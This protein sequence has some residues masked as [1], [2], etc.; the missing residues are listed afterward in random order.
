VLVFLLCGVVLVL[1][2]VLLLPL[3][4]LWSCCSYKLVYV[5]KRLR[6]VEILARENLIS[7]NCGLKLIIGSL[8]KG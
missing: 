6:T 7:N 8:E 1:L 3:G 5:C 2:C 4:A